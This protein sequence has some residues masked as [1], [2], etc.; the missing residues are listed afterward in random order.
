MKFIFFLLI[1]L[2]AEVF[3]VV[4]AQEGTGKSFRW[5]NVTYIN[6]SLGEIY[7]FEGKEIELLAG[8]NS[9]NKLRVDNDTAWLKVCYRSASSSLG[10]LKIFVADNKA[11]KALAS[12][13]TLHGLLN[14]DA[15]IAVTRGEKPLMDPYRFIFPVSFSGG[16][17][18]RNDEDSYF[19]SYQG[20]TNPKIIAG[21]QYPGV[22]LD[23]PN[24]RGSAKFGVLALESG[25]IAWIDTKEGISGQPSAALCLASAT[26]R[27]IYYIYQGLYN[28]YIFVK[29]N[30]EVVRGDEIAYIWGDGLWEHLQFAVVRSDSVPDPRHWSGHL[31]NFFP[32]LME[33]Y[34]G[35]QPA[36]SP[37]FTRGQISFGT[38]TGA[39][40]NIKNASAFEEYQ[41]TGW[42]LDKWN[43]ADKVE[44]VSNKLTG[45]V[46]LSG[47]LFEGQPA[48]CTNPETFYDF[49]ISVPEGI[50]RVRA[51]MGDCYVQ[52][53]QKVEFEN[54]TAGTYLINPGLFTWTPERTVRVKDG[55]LTI[56]IY[57]GEQNQKA[58][59]NSI[60]FQKVY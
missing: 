4:S 3:Q 21:L 58:G 9:F 39:K 42:K 57:L 40:G 6:L 20:G 48:Q 15:L 31:V 47:T 10:E 32:Q 35:K 53:W 28:K 8:R 60:V 11:V 52:T 33:L 38:P 19:L 49:E 22:G 55:Y 24:G 12:D 50:Y 34:Y 37:M 46:R 29:N 44:W 45:N 27:G 1:F 30:Q 5:G 13:R 54:V 56:R 26:D 14:G 36:G 51:N 59:I 7:N 25:K 41:G 2:T 18:W 17:I 43:T 23:I 16:Y